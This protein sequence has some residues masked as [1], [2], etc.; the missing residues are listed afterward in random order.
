M[1]SLSDVTH[2]CAINDGCHSY[3][4]YRYRLPSW[5]HSAMLLIRVLLMMVATT[6]RLTVTA[7]LH[8][9]SVRRNEAA[10]QMQFSLASHVNR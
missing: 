1:V 3:K 2:T 9:L 8:G 10:H 6:T 4:P 5:F 7:F